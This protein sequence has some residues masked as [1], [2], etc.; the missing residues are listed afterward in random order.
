MSSIGKK[1]V[2]DLLAS[3]VA[4]IVF[5]YQNVSFF[6]S[7]GHVVRTFMVFN[8]LELGTLTYRQYR[9]IGRRT[10]QGANMVQRHIAK[11]LRLMPRFLERYPD[12]ECF[13]IPV[14]ARLLKDGRLINMLYESHA[15]YPDSPMSRICI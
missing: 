11:I 7:S 3:G 15:L 12:I 2:E 9:F 1:M 14:Y 6:V 4:P 5:D 13:T 8:S 10:K